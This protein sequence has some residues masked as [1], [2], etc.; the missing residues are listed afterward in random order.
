MLRSLK[1]PQGLRVQLV[2][3]DHCARQRLAALLAVFA[4][5]VDVLDDGAAAVAAM[6]AAQRN[7]SYQL[8]L[9][10]WNLHSLSVLENLSR[11]RLHARGAETQVVV[12]IGAGQRG[13]LPGGAGHRRF[14]GL[15][16]KPVLSAALG[17]LI[18]Q[19][20]ARL[21]VAPRRVL[22]LAAVE[23]LRGAR[24]LVADDGDQH[25]Q[26]VLALLRGTGVVA[27]IA[28]DGAMALDLL[29]RRDY[30]GVLMVVRMPVMDGLEASRR[31]RA[32]ARLAH[33]PI[34]AMSDGMPAA[35]RARCLATGMDDCLCKP[36]ELKYLLGMLVRWMPPIGEGGTALP[37]PTLL[38]RLRRLLWH[39]D[40]RADGVVSVIRAR[41]TGTAGAAAFESVAI[42]VER[43]AH[44]VAFD[45]LQSYIAVC[46]FE[47][48]WPGA[49]LAG[50]ALRVCG[51][52]G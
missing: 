46:G 3:S 12:M 2:D 7:A 44:G 19:L 21:Q 10:D 33:M 6:A 18:A 43:G 31:I 40:G 30:D 11:L 23:R 20:P 48:E 26:A 28:R 37:L 14:D 42:Q 39:G 8:V 27:G 17:R 4:A 49:P 35:L 15:L 32:D 47:A 13:A 24:L 41:L 16:E 25:L 29:R 9:L 51:G 34:L 22:A 36:I 38:A 5:C 1:S 52:H 50:R 45:R